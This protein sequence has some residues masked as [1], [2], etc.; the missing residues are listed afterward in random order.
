MNDI[1][2]LGEAFNE[3][4]DNHIGPNFK[5]MWGIQNPYYISE[6]KWK[7]KFEWFLLMAAVIFIQTMSMH[8]EHF[9]T[10]NKIGIVMAA[11][12]LLLL[13]YYYRRFSFIWTR[14]KLGTGEPTEFCWKLGLLHVS[15]SCTCYTPKTIQYLSFYRCPTNAVMPTLPSNV[16]IGY[17]YLRFLSF[18]VDV[19]VHSVFMFPHHCVVTFIL[20]RN[21]IEHSFR[22]QSI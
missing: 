21:F 18:Y 8:M 7:N 14:R 5:S 6:V 19:H 17:W 3:K 9:F 22:I 4:S 20:C 2:A 13:F 12:L 16:I 10:R 1:D 11:G 15:I